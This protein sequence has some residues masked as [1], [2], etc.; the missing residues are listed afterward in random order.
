[1]KYRIVTTNLKYN[2][3]Q[4]EVKLWHGWK[5]LGIACTLEEAMENIKEDEKARTFKPTVL[6]EGSYEELVQQISLANHQEHGL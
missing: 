3:F 5:A 2:P 1:M 4:Y 6:F